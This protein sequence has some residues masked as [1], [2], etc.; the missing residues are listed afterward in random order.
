MASIGQDILDAGN[1]RM[2]ALT[3]GEITGKIADVVAIWL[4]LQYARG[5]HDCAEKA[6]YEPAQV[7]AIGAASEA[8]LWL[9]RENLIYL[10]SLL[11]EGK[12]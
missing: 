7:E 4:E 1:E 5:V 8:N 3:Y 2:V 6:G 10:F 12:L 11:E 9:A